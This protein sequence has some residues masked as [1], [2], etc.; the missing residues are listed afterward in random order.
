MYMCVYVYMN[1][2]EYVYAY[3]DFYMLI[4]VENKYIYIDR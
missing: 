3:I 2:C 1:I 4:W